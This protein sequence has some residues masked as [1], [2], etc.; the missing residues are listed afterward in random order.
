MAPRQLRLETIEVDSTADKVAKRVRVDSNDESSSQSSG[1]RLGMRVQQDPFG[2]RCTLPDYHS[3][4]CPLH[5]PP[6]FLKI[7]TNFQLIR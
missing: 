5:N 4:G 6:G 2:S 7:Q 3:F 1:S